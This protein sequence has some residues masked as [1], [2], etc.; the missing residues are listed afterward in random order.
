MKTCI[1]CQKQFPNS[2][3]V[4]GKN[5]NLQRR[6]YCLECSPYGKHNTI[7]LDLVSQGNCLSCENKLKGNQ[8][9]YCSKKCKFD[10]RKK[11]LGNYPISCKIKNLKEI[12]NLYDTGLSWREVALKFGLSPSLVFSYSASGNLK[13]RSVSESLKLSK[14]NKNQKHS[15]ESKTKIS[16]ARKKWL[17]ENPDKHNWS[18]KTKHHSSI[19]CEN[20]KKFL[21]KQ[22]IEFAE[23]HKPLLHKNRF[24][25]IDVA[26]PDKKIGIEIN[27]NQHY[28]IN[29][30]LKPYYQNRH[31]LI[32]AD[33]WILYEIPYRAFF[34]EENMKSVLDKILNDIK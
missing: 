10:Y 15:N 25:S 3:K 22:N 33:G 23:E 14:K 32:V 21:K 2:I 1:K 19:P 27:G 5:K 9:M 20:F 30:K 16:E 34:S 8:T 26:F 28:D 7:K 6:K 4:D 11:N 17:K 29:G 12:Q 31:D 13:S 24:F 18:F